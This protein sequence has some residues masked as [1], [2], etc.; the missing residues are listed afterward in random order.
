M[1]IERVPHT[2]NGKR[3]GTF[4]VVDGVYKLY[5]LIARGEKTK[6]LDNKNNAWRMNALALNEARRKGCAYVGILHSI[7]RERLV[8][9]TLID[10]LYGD[11][12]Q[13]SAFAGV[14]QRALNKDRFR[15]CT[16]HSSA[17][18]AKSVKIR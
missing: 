7:G 14:Q 13:I 11:H 10:D 15:F 18:I 16:T 17:F 4:Y 12:S 2:I 3:M 6:L 5:L 9:A 1:V 8:Y